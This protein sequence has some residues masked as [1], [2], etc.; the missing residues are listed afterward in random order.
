MD[1][2]PSYRLVV[3]EVHRQAVEDFARA[4]LACG[5]FPT[6]RDSLAAMIE[7]L[8]KSP[9]TFGD[10][11]RHFKEMKIDQ[12]IVVR[13]PWAITYGVHSERR[14]VFVRSIQY[15]QTRSR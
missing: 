12:Y 1:A 9:T 15:S 3:P 5:E 4:A 7:S 6:F 14:L 8:E 10:L 13:G 2:G 11:Q